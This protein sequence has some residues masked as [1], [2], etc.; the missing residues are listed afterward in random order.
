MYVT[1]AGVE[2]LKSPCCSVTAV[3][4]VTTHFVSCLHFWKFLKVRR[5]NFFRIVCKALNRFNFRTFQVNVWPGFVKGLKLGAV[6]FV[7]CIYRQTHVR[8]LYVPF[9]KENNGIM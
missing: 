6:T 4:I 3:M 5:Q 9:E 8:L 2:M 7:L 1:T